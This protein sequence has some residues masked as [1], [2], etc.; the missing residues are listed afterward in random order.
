MPPTQDENLITRYVLENPWPL[1][2]ILL[3]TAG[4]LAWKGFREG[5]ATRL[6]V[7]AIIAAAGAAVIIIGAL[8]VTAGEHAIRAARTLVQ[9]VVQEDLVVADRL[10]ADDAVLTIGSPTNPG[11]DKSDILL[12]LEEFAAR[13]RVESN[14]IT[15]ERTYGES[16]TV[17][18]VHL[19]CSTIVERFP[20]PTLSRWE[21]R[22]ERQSDGQWRIA[23]ITCTSINNQAPSMDIIR[24]GR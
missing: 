24:S 12:S 17:A 9:S 15:S 2:V 6:R 19:N 20:Y 8:V 5:M 7:A 23:R 3:A 1:G 21:I 18:I 14:S 4:V 11:I 22:V 16:S 10:L 13:E